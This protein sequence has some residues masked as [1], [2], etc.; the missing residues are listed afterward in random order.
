MTELQE[1][2]R[3]LRQPEYI[4]VLLNPLPVYGMACGLAAL[5]V[6]LFLES[7]QA[8]LVALSIVVLAAASAWPVV[9]FGH[10]G[11]DRVYSMADKAGDQWLDAHQDRA[12]DGQWVFYAAGAL[13]LLAMIL[14]VKF[15]GTA[16]PLVLLTLIAALAALGTGGYI[17]HAGG[18]V[19]HTEF[20]N[21]PPPPA[22][23]E[24]D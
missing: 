19:R 5:L 1:V 24:R 2:L 20:R 11:Y 13:A 9:V 4:H 10:R 17:A 22:D 8:Y 6:A 15:P 3:T 14:P 23:K 18:Q 7:R 16:K 12:D 21:G